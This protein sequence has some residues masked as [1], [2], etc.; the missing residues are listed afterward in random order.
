MN[1]IIVLSIAVVFCLVLAWFLNKRAVDSFKY[2]PWTGKE[3]VKHY[4]QDLGKVKNEEAKKKAINYHSAYWDQ[5]RAS[6]IL[7][8]I[9]VIISLVIFVQYALKQHHSG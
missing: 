8:A 4:E 7:I 5:K 2:W 6:A 1:T 3:A 9:G